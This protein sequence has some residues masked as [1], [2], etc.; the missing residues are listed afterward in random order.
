M[1]NRISAAILALAIV[2]AT[3]AGIAVFYDWS[4]RN[5]RLAQGRALKIRI[6]DLTTRSLEQNSPLACL[7]GDLGE[8]V[9]AA[10]ERVIFGA[11]ET[12][13]AALAY[14]AARIAVVIEGLDYAKRAE[15]AFA[16]TLNGARRAIE[17]DR[18][19]LAAQVLAT[20][21][22]C[23]S[24][25]CP[26]FALARDAN[27]LKANIKARAYENYVGRYASAWTVEERTAPAAEKPVDGTPQP[28]ASVAR[29]PGPSPVAK[30]Y[31]F[32]SSA[33]IPPVSIM[34][35]EP[36]LPKPDAKAEPGKETKPAGDAADNAGATIPLPAK[37]PQ[38]EA[39]APPA[40]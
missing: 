25:N 13:A 30:K 16:D 27:A 23:T 20:R 10:C 15:P 21:D 28:E 6:A 36:P 9:E 38:N 33:S 4:A 18:F 22:G 29:P 39:A 34:N 35:P 3:G 26:F 17:L 32:P 19:G 11:P 12:A 37:R 8:A 31:D 5:E 24:E 1:S 14:T 2:L 7:T 40:R